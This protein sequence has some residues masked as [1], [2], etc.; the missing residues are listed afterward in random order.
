MSEDNSS[1]GGIAFVPLMEQ[2]SSTDAGFGGW[3]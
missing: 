3:Q 1:Q 2:Y